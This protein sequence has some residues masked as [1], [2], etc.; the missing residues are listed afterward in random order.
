MPVVAAGGIVD[1]RGLAAAIALGA[2]GVNVGTRFIASEEAQL[3]EGYKEVV[4]AASSDQT[5]R[6]AFVN[7]LLPAASE[8]GYV[9]APR[10]V[11][12]S[13]VDE[14]YGRDD[15]VNAVKGQLVERL[16]TAIRDG[17]AHELLV[18]T[19]E[20]AGVIDEVLPAAEIV[21]RMVAG[22]EEVLRALPRP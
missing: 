8:D 3:G 1:G 12:S 22:A 18:I 10:V 6:A 13:F 21:R 4:L 15:D 9:T 19:G 5:V 2:Q 20:G 14:W 11:R 16:Q 7:E 17:R